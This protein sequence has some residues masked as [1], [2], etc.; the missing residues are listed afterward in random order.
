MK[1]GTIVSFLES[2]AH[3]SLQEQY[4]NAGLIIGDASRE[5][6]GIICCLDSTKEVIEEAIARKANL[7][8]AHH[9][10][11]FSGLKKINGKNYVERAIVTAIKNDIAIYAIHTNLDNVLTGVSGKM[12]AL[13]GL[14]NLQVLAPK[15]QLLK[16]FIVF[17]PAAQADRVRG[18]IFKAGGGDIGNYSECSFNTEG[19][20]TYMASEGSHPFAG[21]IGKQHQEKELKIEVIFPGYLEQDIIRA[22]KAVHPYEEV[23]YDIV[24]LNNTFNGIGSG[25]VGELPAPMDELAFLEHL[26]SVFRLK[27]VRHTRLRQKQVKKV[28]LCGGAG[29]FLINNALGAGAEFYI[30]ADIK[31]HE[32][33]DAN[34][35][36]VVADIGHYESEQFTVD[37]L[38]EILVEKFPNFAVLKTGVVTNPVYYS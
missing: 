17:V 18:A 3:P 14:Q 28:A 35:R 32:F 31:Y 8:I 22:V 24:S 1:I 7:V 6:T 27:L 9:P 34:D 16:K 21:E 19:V 38:Q 2:K 33:F 25:V 29:S 20:G 36:L 26:K 30:S 15:R 11:I 12:A 37:L 13:L 10:I 4:D 23:A 5:C